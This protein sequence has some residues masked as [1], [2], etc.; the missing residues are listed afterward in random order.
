MGRIKLPKGIQQK[1]LLNIAETTDLDWNQIAKLCSVTERTLCDWRREKYLMSYGAFSKLQSISR[2]SL[3]DNFEI[4]PEHWNTKKAGRLGATKRYELYGNPG[5]VEGRR[6]GGLTTWQRYISQPELFKGT[7]FKGPKEIALAPKS[8]LLAEL[9]GI[10]LGD[11]NIN[12]YQLKISLNAKTDVKYADFIYDLCY[13]L[14]K[15]KAAKRVR[16]KNTLDLVLSSVNL[17]NYLVT[18]GLKIGDKIRQS[19]NIPNWILEERKYAVA[20]LRGLVDTDGGIYYHK[21]SVDGITYRHIGICFTSYSPQ[22]LKSVYEIFIK[23][24]FNAK[25][26]FNGGHIFLYRKDEIKKYFEEIGTHNP[27]LL[28]RYDDYLK[29]YRKGEVPKRL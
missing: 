1:F 13:K 21:H 19:V 16:K 14:F 17:T 15:L 23:L 28:N 6:K 7:G 22:L 5:T 9:I 27:T 29:K 20:C 24:G 26:N 12:K 4:L 25:I 2:F 8:V 11:G 10:I 18:L 3:T